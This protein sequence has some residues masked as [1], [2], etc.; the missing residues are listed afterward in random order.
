MS[1]TKYRVIADGNIHSPRTRSSVLLPVRYQVPRYSG[2]KRTDMDIKVYTLGSDTK[3][4]V[5]A[6]GNLRCSSAAPPRR[7][8]S[9]TKYRVIADG[10][11][12]PVD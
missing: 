12:S 1:D 9:D 4:R 8:R 7:A 11:G 6:D 10:N 3:Y 2:W 5:I